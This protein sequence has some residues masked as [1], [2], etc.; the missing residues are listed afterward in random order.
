MEKAIIGIIG[1]V[2]SNKESLWKTYKII[3][4]FR[5]IISQNDAI[6][7]GILPTEKEMKHDL[8]GP[9]TYNPEYLTKE[10]R[11]DLYCVLDKCDGFILQGGLTNAYYEIEIAKYAIEKDVPIIG[12]CAGFNNLIRA[13]GGTVTRHINDEHDIYD[14]YYTHNVKIEKNS[15]LY[16][17]FNEDIVK[18]NS[19]HTMVATDSDIKEYKII[20]HSEDGLV[21]AIELEDKKFVMGF[22]WHP[23]IMLDIDSRMNNIFVEFIKSCKTV[24]KIHAENAN[25]G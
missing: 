17:F 6:P 1:K 9:S 10:E 25:K 8:E 16:E 15:K 4:E 3:D 5:Q 14:K 23:E 24:K 20:A 18:V 22:K 13:L 2:S 7:L 21:E 11:D 19:I 12:V